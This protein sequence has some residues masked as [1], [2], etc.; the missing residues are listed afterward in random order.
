M[1]QYLCEYLKQKMLLFCKL[2]FC[3]F[4]AYY[5]KKTVS[6]FRLKKGH[7]YNRLNNQLLLSIGR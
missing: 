2:Y 6:L 1:I 5:D 4:Y 3:T 7:K